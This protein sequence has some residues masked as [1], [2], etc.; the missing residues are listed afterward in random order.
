VGALATRASA[1]RL[2][3]EWELETGGDPTATLA[4]AR[5]SLDRALELNANLAPL[6]HL[7]GQIHLLASRFEASRTPGAAPPA[8][9]RARAALERARELDGGDA[10]VCVQLARLC[11]RR[12]ESEPRAVSVPET[13]SDGIRWCEAALMLNPRLAEAAALRAVL[14]AATDEEPPTSPE[15][16]AEL[17]VAGESLTA[18]LRA[19][20][21]LAREFEPLWDRLVAR[22]SRSGQ[23]AN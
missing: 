4:R 7:Q 1:L 10:D 23:P 21:F 17:A 11:F 16:A 12:I 9:D 19:N 20:P 15:R 13:A 6:H 22:A 8:F 18:A 14:V 3:A 2:L 5:A